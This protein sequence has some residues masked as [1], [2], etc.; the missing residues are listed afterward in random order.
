MRTAI[1]CGFGHIYW[2]YPYWK[3][4]FF[5]QCNIWHGYY[6]SLEI[7]VCKFVLTALNKELFGHPNA[8]NYFI[9]IFKLV[10]NVSNKFCSLI[11]SFTNIAKKVLKLQKAVLQGWHGLLFISFFL[12]F[13][14][15]LFVLIFLFWFS[16]I[17]WK[18]S[19]RL[20][21]MICW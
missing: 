5:V 8:E 2:R 18:L 20:L 21:S 12:Y 14:F 4:S 19:K 6:F 17:T 9:L 16:L 7:L 15:F 3:T 13:R 11:Q 1:S 10:Q